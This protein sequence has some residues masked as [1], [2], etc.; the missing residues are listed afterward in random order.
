M[1]TLHVRPEVTVGGERMDTPIL[2]AEIYLA[3]DRPDRLEVVAAAGPTSSIGWKRGAAE[4]ALV[5]ASL[6][7]EGVFAGR[8]DRAGLALDSLHG[9]TR[10]F[11]A[12]A[13]YH[14]LRSGKLPDRW[15]QATDSEVAERLAS[16]LELAPRVE[17]TSL[18]HTVVERRGDPLRFLRKRATACGFQFAVVG[19]RLHFSRE[20]P[21]QGETIEISSRGELL[22]L[23]IEERPQPHGARSSGAMAG[24]QL[25]VECSPRFR[26]LG[27]IDLN[28]LDGRGGALYRTVRVMHTLDSDGSRTRVELVDAGLDYALWREQDP[29]SEVVDLE[30]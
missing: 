7:G 3:L 24:G 5:T 16:A 19:G 1:R 6:D 2:R 20:L 14:A 8:L 26:P 15:P 25:E 27:L 18:V 22:S 21:S 28:G 9:R 30:K 10:R 23:E 13:S 17:R 11:V 29:E 12:H 4:G